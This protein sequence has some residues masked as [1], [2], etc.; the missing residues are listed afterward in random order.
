MTWC[1]SATRSTR[2]GVVV[3]VSWVAGMAVLAGAGML[4]VVLVVVGVAV[5]AGACK[6][7]A[8]RITNAARK[9]AIA[10]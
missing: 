4:M 7:S 3:V 10:L 9:F 8:S 5:L 1:A 6:A 2:S